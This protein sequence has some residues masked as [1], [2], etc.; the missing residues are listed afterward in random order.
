MA[1]NRGIEPAPKKR[2][3]TT[4]QANIQKTPPTLDKGPRAKWTVWPPNHPKRPDGRTGLS[5]PP[6]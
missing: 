6:A 5:I 3:A 2:R 1:S 4:R